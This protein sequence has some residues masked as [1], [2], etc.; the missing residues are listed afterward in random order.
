MAT[1]TAISV[2]ALY[3]IAVAILSFT[4]GNALAQQQNGAANLSD[5]LRL[6][7]STGCGACHKIART[8]AQGTIGP[9]LTHL[10]SR[11]MIGA[12]LLPMTAENLADWIQ[13]TQKLKP[14]AR[15]PAFGML[16][17]S[18]TNAIVDYLVTLK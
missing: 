3:M 13:H 9:D 5:G 18:E 10:A 1:F 8:E 12:N 7:L 17:E 4:P 11:E 16:P 6:F 2:Q 15:M 14:G